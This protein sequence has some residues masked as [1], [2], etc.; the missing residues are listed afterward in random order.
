MAGESTK[1]V[2]WDVQHGSSTYINTPN[3]KNIVLDLGTGSYEYGKSFSPL[4]HLKKKHN[5]SHLDWVIISH[6]HKDHIDDI[7]NFDELSPSVFSRPRNIPKELVMSKTRDQDKELFE[8]YFEI[9]DR[10]NSPISNMNNLKKPI[11]SGGVV[12][13]TFYSKSNHTANINNYSIV[14]VLSY[15]GQKV[16][17]PG[18]NEPPSWE[19]LLENNSFVKAI[20]GKGILL[21][22]HH[23]RESGF[24]DEIFDYFSPYLTIVSDGKW[25]DTSATDRYS[26][27]SEGW[28]VYYR[29]GEREKR[30]CLTT[31]KD[32]YVVVKIGYTNDRTKPYINIKARG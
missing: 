24:Y 23:G 17:L 6:P 16:I 11:N 29:N 32:G 14:T 10:Y 15:A 5:I 12:V 2:F 28:L 27:L 21:A 19:K 31:R 25:C 4:I 22:P 13:Q 20:T 30:Y 7:M 9:D 3:G 8:K 18:D 1:F 26:N